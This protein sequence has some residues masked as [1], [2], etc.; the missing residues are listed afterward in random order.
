MLGDVQCGLKALFQ[1]N[2]DELYLIFIDSKQ[3]YDS[4]D[5]TQLQS[6]GKWKSFQKF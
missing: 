4:I 5:R 2:D 1:K 3:A 6:E